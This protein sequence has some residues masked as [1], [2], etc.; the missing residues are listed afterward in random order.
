MDIDAPMGKLAGS[1]FEMRI[2]RI[3]M[4]LDGACMALNGDP[5]LLALVSKTARKPHQ[6]AFINWM[7]FAQAGE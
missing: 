4:E 6:Q 2:D 5:A 1:L 3:W 7:L